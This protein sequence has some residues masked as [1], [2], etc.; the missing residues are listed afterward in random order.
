MQR[1]QSHNGVCL[2]PRQC[3]AMPLAG[4]AGRRS[5]RA[6]LRS[7]A[8]P[9]RHRF[10]SAKRGDDLRGE[11][12][13]MRLRPAWRQPWRQGPGVE[14]GDRHGVR[15]VADHAY[16]S[17]RV[18]DFEQSALAQVLV[19]IQMRCKGLKATRVKP[20]RVVID[21]I[22]DMSGRFRHGPGG[23]PGLKP[24]PNRTARRTA[25]GVKPPSQI[26]GRGF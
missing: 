3:S 6:T 24:S 9:R 18:D 15:E 12:L 11:Q 21:L 19:V 23:E 22:D 1:P 26:G 17:V 14:V 13:Q 25:A 7:L 10:R 16:R 5:D 2:S 8:N 20:F 4:P